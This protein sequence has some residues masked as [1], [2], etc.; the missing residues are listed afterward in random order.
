VCD[1]SRRSRLAGLVAVL[2]VLSGT[3]AEAQEPEP[4]ER[5]LAQVARLWSAGDAASIARLAPADGRI[6]LALEGEGAS[7]VPARHAAARLRAYFATRETLSA[8]PV[9]AN[10]SGGSP[11][12]GFGEIAWSYRS[13]GVSDR[14]TGSIFIGVVSEE[15]AWRIRELRLIP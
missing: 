3:P 1:V 9:R 2:L 8:R 11:L 10:V 7:G 15:G 14:Q 5:F 13:R 12:R 6:S 4:L